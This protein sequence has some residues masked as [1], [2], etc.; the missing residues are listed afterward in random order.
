VFLPIFG[1]ADVDNGVEGCEDDSLVVLV[2][3]VVVI[4]VN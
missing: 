4:N 1:G 2:V 3:E